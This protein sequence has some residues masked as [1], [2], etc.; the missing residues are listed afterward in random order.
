MEKMIAI[1]NNILNNMK[2]N[3]KTTRKKES[4]P[5]KQIHLFAKSFQQ[6]FGQQSL[7]NVM[8][9]MTGRENQQQ[10]QVFCLESTL[11]NPYFLSIL[12][13]LFKG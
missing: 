6:M 11:S 4:R 8:P 1:V 12:L 3:P 9:L 5:S 7:T 13:K 10:Q 2:V